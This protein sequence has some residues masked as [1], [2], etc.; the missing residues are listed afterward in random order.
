MYEAKGKELS[1]TAVAYL[2]SR[3]A[4]PLCSFGDFVA[5]S[6]VVDLST[7]QL[8][9]IEVSDGI[10]APGFEPEALEILKA[11]KG[12]K[13]I[14]LQVRARARA[15]VRV[16]PNL[17]EPD[18]QRVARAAFAVELHAWLGHGPGSG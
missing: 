15:R 16:S 5:V 10:I 7:A 11:K 17:A 6:E 4:D 9:K 14:L 18:D 13:Y 3:Q 1:K 2:R 12:G 8:L